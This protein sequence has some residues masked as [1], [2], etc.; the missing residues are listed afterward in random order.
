MNEYF[1]RFSQLAE[2]AIG[3][4]KVSGALNGCLWLT[5]I[6]FPVGLW[7]LTKLTGPIQWAVFAMIAAPLLFFGISH[8]HFTFTDPDKLR[9]EDFELRKQALELIEEKGGRIPIS[10][11]SIELIANPNYPALTSRKEDD[12]HG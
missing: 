6:T 8:F 12:A 1:S 11:A 7:A 5:G 4:L 10:D 3:R 9:S 2:S